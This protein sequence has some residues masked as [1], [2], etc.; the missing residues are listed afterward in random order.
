VLRYAFRRL[1]TLLRRPVDVYEPDPG[2]VS[3]QH[4]VPVVVL[5]R[6]TLRVNVY[7][8]AGAGRHPVLTSAHPYGKDNLPRRGRHVSILYRMLRQT[9][10][11]PM[12]PAILALIEELRPPEHRPAAVPFV[13][14]HVCPAAAVRRVSGVT[15]GQARTWASHSPAPNPRDGRPGQ[16][17]ATP[18]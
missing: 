14:A 13:S 3:V 18:S 17:G 6:T 4:D 15:P 7:P 11:E 5:E 10:R 1:P 9:G 12:D 8:T 2:S 16:G